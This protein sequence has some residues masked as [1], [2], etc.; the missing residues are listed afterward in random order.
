MTQALLTA[1]HRDPDFRG[2]ISQAEVDDLSRRMSVDVAGLMTALLPWA[3]TFSLPPI[4]NFRVGA[5]AR[6]ASG[7]L[8][9]GTNLE[10][11]A[12]SLGFTVH[13]EQSAVINAWL[14]GEESLAG[15]AVT[16]APCGH[17]RQFL[18][19]LNAS[20]EIVVVTPKESRPLTELLPS[21]FGPRDLGIESG[22][23]S[24][25]SHRL[26]MDDDEELATAALDSADHSYAPY[27]NAFAGVALRLGDDSVI[28]GRYAENAAFN[29]SLSPLNVALARMQLARQKFDSITEA[30]LVQTEPLHT[31]VTQTLLAA[32]SGASLRVL[33]ARKTN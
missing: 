26:W 4:S 25:V 32:V 5:V 29:P 3:A 27:S 30:V 20:E 1:M 8:Y 18:N 31:A 22:L 6:G 24:A 13:A 28:T 23:M 21:A 11:E 17:C 14:E 9:Y 10:V 15:I 12:L 16:A 19:E 33:Q 2:V 7:A